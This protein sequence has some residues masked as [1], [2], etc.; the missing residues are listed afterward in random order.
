MIQDVLRPQYPGINN[1]RAYCIC[2]GEGL[3][4][5]KRNKTKRISVS[6][7]L[8]AALAVNQIWS[9]DL[10]SD[11]IKRSGAVSRRVKCLTVVDDFIHH[12][13]MSIRWSL[14]KAGMQH[15]H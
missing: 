8:V 13:A 11:A 7:L 15:S 4:I 3:S 5:S 6:T 2:S 10:V 14:R 1:K 12:W 9:M